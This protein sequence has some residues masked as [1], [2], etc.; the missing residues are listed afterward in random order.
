MGI[1]SH[2]LRALLVA[3]LLVAGSFVLEATSALPAE[4]CAPPSADH[5]YGEVYS[6]PSGI[7]GVYTY[8]QPSCLSIPSGNFVT[9]EAWLTSSGNTYWV[10]AGY[11]QEGSGLNIGGI[12]S[13]GRYAFYGDNR[14]GGGFHDHVMETNPPFGVDT[15]IWKNTSSTWYANVDGITMESTS[16]T[17]TSAQG[18]WGSETT[19]DTGHSLAAFS[20]VEYYVGSTWHSG[21]S[22]FG[23]LVESP[24]TFSWTSPYT[25]FKAGSPC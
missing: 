13:A 12:T 6:S 25:A 11:L 10:E 24:Q 8:I 15:E 21:L 2:R 19:S 3:A 1:R 14:P 5:C 23:T 4:A 22:S 18:I 9:D 16:N 17:M 20:S 7:I